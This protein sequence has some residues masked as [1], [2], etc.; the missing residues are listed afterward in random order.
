MS[1]RTD[2]RT[3]VA[4][5]NPISRGEAARLLPDDVHA[6][7]LEAVML[8]PVGA[9]PPSPRTET[10]ERRSLMRRPTLRAAVIVAVICLALASLTL[11]T[12]P[13]RAVGSWVGDQL[14]FGE[15]GGQPTLRQLRHKLV[16]GPLGR[17]F[18]A[19][20]GG[21]PAYVLARGPAP[22]GDR[23]E[24]ITFRSDRTGAHCFEVELPRS[25]QLVG[26]G[27]KG[28]EPRLAREDG[29]T[30]GM[31]SH[32]DAVAG[33]RKLMVHGRIS[34]NVDSVRV[35]LDG[36]PVPVQVVEPPERL[37]EE[38]GFSHSFKVFLSFPA[39][40]GR[41]GTLRVRAVKD[42]AVVADE[43]FTLHPLR[44]HVEARQVCEM[45]RRLAEEGRLSKKL[46][47]RTCEDAENGSG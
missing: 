21:R 31:S 39:D 17:T 6:R 3:A 47:H 32:G 45:N 40:G 41:G 1:P 37:L 34:D 5:A 15:P 25:R 11:F 43:R 20:G 38:L 42:G 8:E 33:P 35:T 18:F 23:W 30:V 4:A 46:L 12:A 9:P 10:K 44:P 29:L 24:F 27:C 22:N 13:G 36:R 28:E 26:G 14:G 2:V 7:F 19:Q 16:D